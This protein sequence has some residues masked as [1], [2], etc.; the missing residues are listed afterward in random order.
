MGADKNSSRRRWR[1]Q[2]DEQG[3]QHTSP[4]HYPSWPSPHSHWSATGPRNQHTTFRAKTHQHAQRNLHGL[5]PVLHRSD[6][7]PVPVR[8]VTPFRPVATAAAQQVFQRASVTSLGPGTKPPQNT[9]CTEG[10]PYTKPNKTTP[11][12]PRTDQQHQDPK[13]HESSS[14]PEANPTSD[15][16]RSDRSRAPVRPV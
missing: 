4:T 8:P 13:T 9:T 12:K 1:L 6:R 7:C 5:L 11:N 2:Q 15:L 10:K 16:H 14:S 3:F